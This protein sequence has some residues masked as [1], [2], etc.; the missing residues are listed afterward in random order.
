MRRVSRLRAL[1]RHAHTGRRSRSQT[2]TPG[3]AARNTGASRSALVGERPAARGRDLAHCCPCCSSRSARACSS[4]VGTASATVSLSG[5]APSK[6]GQFVFPENQRLQMAA[7]KPDTGGSGKGGGVAFALMLRL[8][9]RLA[10]VP[11]WR[12]CY[13]CSHANVD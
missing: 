2:R 3:L 4:S 5:T 1:S 7:R 6:K 11:A 9:A 8:F 10:L 13:A 12:S